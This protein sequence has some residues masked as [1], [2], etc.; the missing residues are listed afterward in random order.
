LLEQFGLLGLQL[1]TLL[2]N[3][4]ISGKDDR[5]KNWSWASMGVVW[6]GGP[7]VASGGMV[8]FMVGVTT[9]VSR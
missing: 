4:S 9:G 7:R 2:S 1:L 3:G 5:R 8:I 6:G